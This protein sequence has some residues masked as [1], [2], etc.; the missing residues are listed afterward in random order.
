MYIFRVP[1]YAIPNGIL[2]AFSMRGLFHQLE[3][4]LF[5]SFPAIQAMKPEHLQIMSALRLIQRL[6]QQ[7][8]QPLRQVSQLLAIGVIREPLS[9]PE[10]RFPLNRAVTSIEGCE[11]SF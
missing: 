7:I 6:V 5:H 1:L 2:P 4:G 9:M 10:H 3:S 11:I 8:M